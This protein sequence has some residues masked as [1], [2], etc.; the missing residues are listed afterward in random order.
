MCVGR[1]VLLVLALAIGH[2]RAD[3]SSITRTPT[4]GCCDCVTL[5]PDPR[6]NIEPQYMPSPFH[7]KVSKTVY[8]PKNSQ[9]EEINVNLTSVQPLTAFTRFMI[10]AVY[11]NT[12]G[13]VKDNTPLGRFIDL[14]YNSTDPELRGRTEITC[15][16]GRATKQ[17]NANQLKKNVRLVWKPDVTMKGPIVFRATFIQDGNRFWVRELSEPVIDKN[18][19][20]MDKKPT[21]PN[22]LPL[23]DPINTRDCGTKKGCFRIP[24]GCWEPYCQYIATWVHL[25][26][27]RYRFEV[28]GITDGITDRYVSLAISNDIR[29]GGDLVMECVH[30]G[31]TGLTQVYL[32]KSV[33]HFTHRLKNPKAGIIAEEGQFLNG[34]LRC[35]FEKVPHPDTKDYPMSG[36]SHLLMSRGVA[37]SGEAAPHRFGVGEIP[38]SSADEITLSSTANIGDYARYSLVKGHGILMILAW[39]FFGTTGM[40]LIKYYQTMWPNKRFFSHRYWFIGHINCMAWL[41]L[42]VIIAIILIFVEVDGYSKADYLPYK[43]HPILGIIIFVCVILCFIIAL[44]R[45]DED[46]RC[47]PVFNW[48][49]W[50]FGT[51]AWCLAIPNMFIGMD[52]GKSMVPWWATWILCIYILFH[53]IV[54]ITLEV[55]QCCTHK[56]NKERRKKYEFQKRDNPKAYIPEPEPAGR[57]FKKNMLLAHFIVTCIVAL[58]M[59]ISIAAS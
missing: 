13:T 28:G 57:R 22:R 47:R 19:P 5:M 8:N 25:G 59:V 31:A 53:I 4:I 6:P 11:V 14:D 45:P 24:E 21:D 27:N 51:V 20:P 9:A 33:D 16:G 32:A 55:H 29:W 2:A 15:A 54:E 49:Y 26:G 17:S 10:Q 56:K 43:A 40:L 50:L 58:I 48:F 36:Y 44:I 42:L 46:N 38:L 1:V 34:R 30:N 41:L 18:G 7:I 23:I 3:T 39:C 52:F 37:E 12:D 35:R